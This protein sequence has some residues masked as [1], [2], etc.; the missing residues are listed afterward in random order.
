MDRIACMQT[1]VR[2]VETGS[3]SLVAQEAHT[4]QP[5]ISKQVAALEAHLDAHLLTRSTRGISLTAAGHRFYEQA[6]RVLE[7]YALAESSVGIRQQPAGQLRVSCSVAFGQFQIVPRIPRF[8]AQYPAIQLDLQMTHQYVD[9]VEEGIDVAIRIGDL[10]DSALVAHG[11]GTAHRVVVGT[12]AYFARYGE[13]RTPED[14]IHHNCLTYPCFSSDSD[15]HFQG[16]LGPS[17][18]RVHG[19]FRAS[20]PI[21]IREAVLA[22]LGIT[23]GSVWLFADVLAQGKA[24]V[25]LQAY[26]LPPMPIHALHCRNRLQPIRSRCFVDFLTKEF[27]EEP[28]LHLPAPYPVI[29]AHQA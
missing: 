9:L 4:T 18:V 1:F 26:E 3:F 20:S 24:Q 22:G 21:A 14:L 7:E 11:L 16:P 28:L 2:V 12:P 10:Q 8:L 5:T 13:P 6:K 19:N 17:K 27:R 25:V 15:W 29:T 23:V